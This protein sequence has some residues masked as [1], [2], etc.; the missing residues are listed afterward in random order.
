[1][2]LETLA[3]LVRWTMLLPVLGLLL[4][5]LYF[6]WHA[7]RE[8]ALALGKGLEK[9]LPALVGAVDL[10]LLAA[11][12]LLFGLGLFELFIRRLDLPLENVLVV[13]SLSDLKEKLGQV[14]VMILVVKFFERALA[15]KPQTALDFL[16]FAGGVALL[17]AALWLT[18][19]KD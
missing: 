17:A 6:A 7:L 9:A 12:F 14:I 18:R 16:L 3:H 11:V 10:A 2:R 1:M 4:G 5:A 8:A 19:A 13:E 15:F